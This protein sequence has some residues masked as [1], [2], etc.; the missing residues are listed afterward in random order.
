MITKKKIKVGDTIYIEQAWEDENGH[1]HDEYAEVLE[2]DEDGNMS[3]K[4][5]KEEVNKFLA[6]AEF[7]VED[8]E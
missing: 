7:N 6:N 1:F 4:F 8:Y 5:S 3:L 2:I